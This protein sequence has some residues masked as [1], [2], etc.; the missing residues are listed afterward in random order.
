MHGAAAE[1]SPTARSS[2]GQRRYGERDLAWLKGLTMLRGT[3]MFTNELLWDALWPGGA[4][5]P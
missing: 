2:S 4:M 3:G 5:R 1:L